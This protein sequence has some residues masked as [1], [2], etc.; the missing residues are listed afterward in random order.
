[1]LCGILRLEVG[2]DHVRC[3]SV[4]SWWSSARCFGGGENFPGGFR[5][6][7]SPFSTFSTF[8]T[9]SAFSAFL[10]LS[11]FSAFFKA[12]SFAP[13][14][15]C[16]VG[17]TA[18]VFSCFSPFFSCFSCSRFSCLEG[19]K[20]SRGSFPG[21]LRGDA[22]VCECGI[23]GRSRLGDRSHDRDRGGGRRSSRRPRSPS[24][25][26]RQSRR[27]DRPSPRSDLGGAGRGLQSRSTV[28][29]CHLQS[30]SNFRT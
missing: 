9:F 19:S 15:F 22:V 25:E 24:P 14:T 23:L 27:G 1:M 20:C 16:D 6:S 28:D 17:L 26:R 29:S 10:S 12:L 5:F 2:T 8:S 4:P 30:V 21:F 7:D 3:P 11:V 18:S 13:S